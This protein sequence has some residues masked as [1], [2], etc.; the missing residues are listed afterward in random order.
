[1][2]FGPYLF[3]VVLALIIALAAV[4]YHLVRAAR[5][6]PAQTLKYE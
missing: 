3:A 6:N 1:M 2:G 5:E 4:S